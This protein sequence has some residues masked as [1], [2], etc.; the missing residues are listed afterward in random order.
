[1]DERLTDLMNQFVGQGLIVERDT[2]IDRLDRLLIQ[3]SAFPDLQV[4]TTIEVGDIINVIVWECYA[5]SVIGE[6]WTADPK[7]LIM[8]ALLKIVVF[9]FALETALTGIN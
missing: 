9:D 6:F 1:M 2:T 5:G 4:L 3:F 7:E 8:L